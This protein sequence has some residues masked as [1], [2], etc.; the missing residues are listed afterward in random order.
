MQEI[1]RSLKMQL[2]E[3]VL[4]LSETFTKAG[5]QL[6]VVGGAV[7]DAVLGLVPKDVDLAT[8]A[9]PDQVREL[10]A[11]LLPQWTADLTGE[12]FGVIRTGPSK[13]YWAAVNKEIRELCQYEIATFREDLTAGRHP[14]VRFATIKEDVQRRD[15]TIN[16]LFYDIHREEVVDLVGGLRDLDDGIVRM[17]GRPQDRFA[18]DRLRIL[19]AIRFSTRFG[20]MLAEG[21]EQAILADNSLEGISP[22]RIRDEFLRSLQTAEDVRVLFSLYDYFNLWPQVLPGLQVSTKGLNE[23]RQHL[24]LALLLDGNSVDEVAR[25]LNALRYSEAEVRQVTFLMKF[26]DM[27]ETDV[28]RMRK[29]YANSHLGH[30]DLFDYAFLRM[31]PDMD[32]VLRFGAYALCPPISGDTLLAE[33]YSGRALGME[34]ERRELE[35][36]GRLKTL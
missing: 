21:T 11:S 26:R 1:R 25:R 28:F 4:R 29:L 36:F 35:L 6:F 30:S 33:G 10:I 23:R 15:L 12:A 9:T 20:F 14:E 5:Y 18:E 8:N 2:P 24:V 7:R 34:L 19:R 22:E 27:K 13:E 31:M 16:A 32:L 3:T 17:V